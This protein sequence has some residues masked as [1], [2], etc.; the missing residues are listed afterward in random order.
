MTKCNTCGAIY[1]PILPDGM[2]YFH[3]CSP[4]RKLRVQQADLSIVLVD[5]PL[6]GGA[7]LLAEEFV[8][9]VNHRDENVPSTDERDAGK[10]KLPGLGITKL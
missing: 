5:P 2:L 3:A 9:R 6:P 10:V 8:N 7:R 4:V 1:E